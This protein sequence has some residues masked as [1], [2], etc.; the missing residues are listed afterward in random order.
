M[1]NLVAASL[2]LFNLTVVFNMSSVIM[3]SAWI[4]ISLCGLLLLFWINRRVH[5][6]PMRDLFCGLV[7]ACIHGARSRVVLV[8]PSM[9]LVIDLLVL[10][11]IVLPY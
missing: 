5:F 9:L 6:S 4:V 1:L 3:Q 10:A 2:V 7:H 11:E 8:A